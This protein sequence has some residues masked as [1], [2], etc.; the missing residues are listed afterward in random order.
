MLNNPIFWLQLC[1]YSISSVVWKSLQKALD[2]SLLCT[3]PFT[4]AKHA[5]EINR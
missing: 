5:L 4:I 2:V 3:K 1:I